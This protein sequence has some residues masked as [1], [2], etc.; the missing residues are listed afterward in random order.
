MVTAPPYV[1]VLHSTPD[2]PTYVG[3]ASSRRVARPF[4]AAEMQ[5]FSAGHSRQ[6]KGIFD[7]YSEK[8]RRALLSAT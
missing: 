5:A 2:A 8:V 7:I 3:Q 1:G 4:T 6:L